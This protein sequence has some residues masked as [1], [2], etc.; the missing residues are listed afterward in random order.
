VVQSEEQKKTCYFDLGLQY[1]YAK[2][3]SVTQTRPCFTARHLLST[4]FSQSEAS[5]V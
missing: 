3:A 2:T 1:R 5:G 4:S